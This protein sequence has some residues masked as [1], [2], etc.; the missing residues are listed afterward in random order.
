MNVI[1]SFSCR[2][3]SKHQI[4]YFLLKV[5]VASIIVCLLLFV[6]YWIALF[7]GWDVILDPIMFLF[8][9]VFLVGF[10]VF[11]LSLPSL[12]F[13]LLMRRNNKK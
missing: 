4:Y 12:M 13:D 5:V 11:I 10:I 1:K 9:A 2:L 3:K 6:F 7:V 8:A